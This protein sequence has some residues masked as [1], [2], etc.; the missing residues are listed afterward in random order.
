[1]K[2]TAR[3]T[4]ITAATCGL[5]LATAAHAADYWWNGT[6]KK[7]I[8]GTAVSSLGMLAVGVNVSLVPL[9]GTLML[10]R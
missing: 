1:M 9:P 6:T 10:V 7:Q 5:L 8:T 3:K 2:T 4:G